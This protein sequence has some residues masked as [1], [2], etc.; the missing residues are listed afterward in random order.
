MKDKQQ[1]CVAAQ[2]DDNP[3][4][5][6]RDTIHGR[7]PVCNAIVQQNG[8]RV[9]CAFWREHADKL[10]TC[11]AGNCVLLYQVLVEKK[12]EGSW[13]LGSWR[14][15]QVL[16]CPEELE[17]TIRERIKEP[18]DC[19]M[20]TLI[21]TRNWKEC[22]AVPST[23]ILLVAAIVPGQLRKVDT[24]CVI[25]GQIMGLSS[26]RSETDEWIL[27]SCST[28]K[29]CAQAR[30]DAAEEKGLALRAVFAD[31]DCQCSMVLYHEH[32]ESA[33]Q[34]QGHTAELRAGSR[35]DKHS[36]PLSGLAK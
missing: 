17:E 14:G 35:R 6:E 28:C 33:M 25:S 23:L 18:S 19:R 7:V 34:Q 32:V 12:K 36:R 9:R 5:T 1:I 3:G 26:V 30:P 31:R 20:L 29:R 13:E 11:Q 16:E 24:V 4:A 15:T 22:E 21:A 2:V 8:T 27:S 10:A